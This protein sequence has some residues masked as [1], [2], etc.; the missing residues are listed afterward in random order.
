MSNLQGLKQELF[1][2]MENHPR[3]VTSDAR[4][5]GFSEHLDTLYEGKLGGAKR[6]FEFYQFVQTSQRYLNSSSEEEKK[7]SEGELSRYAYRG[8]RAEDRLLMVVFGQGA[9]LP[10]EQGGMLE[11]IKL[12]ITENSPV[13]EESY[14]LR[15]EE[16]LRTNLDKL[17]GREYKPIDIDKAKRLLKEAVDEDLSDMDTREKQVL[18]SCFGL[19][20]GKRRTYR[21]VGETIA[22][23]RTGR[24][25]VSE[26]T[27]RRLVSSA[28]RNFRDSPLRSKL[29]EY[30]EEDGK[31]F[32]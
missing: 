32:N 26:R 19:E 21:E 15:F 14:R 4:R 20:D 11:F 5:D 17:R 22:N 31:D 25:G 27:V 8:L 23:K 29:K 2:Y 16:G 28:R 24:V 10:E 18:I 9:F 1:S 12:Y 3:A 13:Y 6:D 7:L 30:L